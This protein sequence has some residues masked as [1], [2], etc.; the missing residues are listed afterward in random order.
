MPDVCMAVQGKKLIDELARFI[1]P[2]LAWPEKR[3]AP[4]QPHGQEMPVDWNI[5]PRV[6]LDEKQLEV[7]E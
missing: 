4:G 3:F 5:V 2:V 7:V 1:G 6:V